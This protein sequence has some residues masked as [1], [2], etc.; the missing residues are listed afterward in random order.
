MSQFLEEKTKELDALCSKHKQELN[1][2]EL[3]M[4]NLRKQSSN[5]KSQLDELRQEYDEKLEKAESDVEAMKDEMRQIENSRRKTQKKL[6]EKN[7]LAVK[8]QELYKDEIKKRKDLHNEMIDMKGNIRVFCRIRPLNDK[9]IT[10]KESEMV[11]A[12]DEF[13]VGFQVDGRQSVTDYDVVFGNDSTQEEIFEDTK[14]LIQSAVDG[15]NV[16]IF[17]YGATGSGKTHTIQGPED[18]PG[19]CPRALSELFRIKEDY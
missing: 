9:E 1:R 13:K 8:Y 10:R 7:N 14:R 3:Q 6:V 4:S 18:N 5:L 11:Q 12:I 2:K 17:A 19:V 16:C 15:Y